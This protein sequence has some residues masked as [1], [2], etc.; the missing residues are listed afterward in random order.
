MPVVDF[1]KQNTFPGDGVTQK[2]EMLT[3]KHL[4]AF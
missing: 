2:Q 1:D 4:S 3:K